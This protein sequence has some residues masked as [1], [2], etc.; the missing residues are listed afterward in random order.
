[1]AMPVAVCLVVCLV[2]AALAVGSVPSAAQELQARGIDRVCPA[3][4]AGQ[5]DAGEDDPEAGFPDLGTT[6][7]PAISCAAD[8]G[9]V[10][11]FDDGTFQPARPITRGQMATF[12][13]A[14]IRVATGARLPDPDERTFSDIE[15]DIHAASIAAVAD[16]GIVGGRADGTFA[17]QETLTRGQFTRA[18][19]NAI[20]YADVFAVG[21]PLPPP[22]TE[23]ALSD[24]GG[25]T[26]EETIQSLAGVG[27]ALGTADGAFQPD[28]A[29][30]RGQLTTFLM[31]AADYLDRH[32]RWK[33][34]ALSGA[35]LVADL[36]AASDQQ[37]A[38]TAAQATATL[39]LNAFNG[40]LAYSLDLSDAP[41]PYGT[42][43]AAIHLGDPGEDGPVALALADADELAAATGGVVTGVV[44]EA[45]SA[46][47][48][49]DLLA[50][51]GDAYVQ[52]AIDGGALRGSLRSPTS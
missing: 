25:T 34:T 22:G 44:L 51:P 36:V 21:G 9:I 31:R 37:D 33:P 49:A 20:S 5:P 43:G 4:G 48:F 32:Q 41:G 8:Y 45:D 27:I 42:Q 40:T 39:S 29:V 3:P 46:V 14:W 2:V 1:M 38:G 16:A 13:A 19:A 10:S 11:G 23:V 28:A 15:D 18:V 7:A 6:H 24:I 30:T 50:S 47:R 17:P 35:V 12:L 26:F 52:V